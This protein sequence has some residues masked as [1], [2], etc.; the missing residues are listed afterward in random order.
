MD[1]LK[2]FPSLNLASGVAR[3]CYQGA[4][5]NEGKKCVQRRLI[6]IGV[7]NYFVTN[8]NGKKV[9]LANFKVHNMM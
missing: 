8:E 7:V 6:I 2:A 9:Y 5:R 1:V 3:E 4:R